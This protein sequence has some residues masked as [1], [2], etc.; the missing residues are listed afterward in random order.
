MHNNKDKANAEAYVLVQAEAEALSICQSI[1]Y[2][3]C[4]LLYDWGGEYGTNWVMAQ[5]RLKR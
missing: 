5:P 2:W 3:D 4:S 1:Q